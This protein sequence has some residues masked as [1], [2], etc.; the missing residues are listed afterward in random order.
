VKFPCNCHVDFLNGVCMQC[1][2]RIELGT[3]RHDMAVLVRQ[4]PWWA[5][6]LACQLAWDAL[7]FHLRTLLLVAVMIA[8]L[9][10]LLWLTRGAPPCVDVHGSFFLKGTVFDADQGRCR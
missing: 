7:V 3:L 1:G 9:T 5:A 10:G 4:S 2:Q 8:G 6:V